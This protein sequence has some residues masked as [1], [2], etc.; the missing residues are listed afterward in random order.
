MLVDGLLAELSAMPQLEFPTVT[1]PLSWKAAPVVASANMQM[2]AVPV[3]ATACTPKVKRPVGLAEPVSELTAPTIE[4]L[5]LRDDHLDIA[6][7][8]GK[9]TAGRRVIDRDGDAIGAIDKAGLASDRVR[10]G[11]DGGVIC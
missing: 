5:R 8:T 4:R 2:L 9:I 11:C 10:L 6:R 1:L 7:L 3:V